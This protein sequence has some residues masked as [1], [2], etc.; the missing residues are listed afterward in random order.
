MLRATTS[1]MASSG[2][3]L[4]AKILQEKEEGEEDGGEEKMGEVKAESMKSRAV[5]L[6]R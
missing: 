5:L 6:R 2:P 4:F 3:L 1:R